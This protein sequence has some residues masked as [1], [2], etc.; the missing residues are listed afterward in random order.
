MTAEVALNSSISLSGVSALIAR[1]TV[2]GTVPGAAYAA[3]EPI[4]SNT[5]DLHKME[6]DALE[7]KRRTLEE[8]NRLEREGAKQDH[9]T[10]TGSV[11]RVYTAEELA[12]S[13]TDQLKSYRQ[14]ST[15]PTRSSVT[16]LTSGREMSPAQVVYL[17]RTPSTS[18]R[19]LSRSSMQRHSRIWMPTRPSAS[20]S[21]VMQRTHS[22]PSRTVN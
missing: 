7:E 12:S 3:L 18:S 1:F 15:A 2:W 14:T 5:I 4:I 17:T 9:G 20:R 13:T 11:T 10:G 6:N 21:P 19:W 16:R 22:R 8:I